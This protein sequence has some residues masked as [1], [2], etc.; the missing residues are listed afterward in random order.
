MELES[1]NSFIEEENS[2]PN[3]NQQ[4]RDL[5]SDPEEGYFRGFDHYNNQNDFDDFNPERSR[6][7]WDQDNDK[8]D[9]DDMALN[10]LYNHV[11]KTNDH[12]SGKGILQQESN[13]YE[14]CRVCDKRW[15][16]IDV[17]IENM[18][19]A[20]PEECE[21][22]LEFMETHIRMIQQCV[23]KYNKPLIKII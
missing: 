22:Y 4:F 8:W 19:G 23:A 13:H 7:K 5:G 2:P 9:Q 16:V 21:T 14:E 6:N 11:V 12:P 18:E 10:N 15:D 20:T 17:L 1:S 3:N